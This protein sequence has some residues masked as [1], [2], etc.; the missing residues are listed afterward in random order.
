MA[1]K[2]ISGR[3]LRHGALEENLSPGPS[4]LIEKRGGAGR[5]LKEVDTK[6]SVVMARS[7]GETHGWKEKHTTSDLWHL[8]A[9]WSLSAGVFLTFDQSQGKVAAL[10]GMA[11]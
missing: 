11:R 7:L 8:A 10:M 4:L 5:I 3:Q 9:A 1:T 6:E 2:R